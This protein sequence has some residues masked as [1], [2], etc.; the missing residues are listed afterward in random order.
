MGRPVATLVHDAT[1]NG[2]GNVHAGALH[3]A[4]PPQVHRPAEHVAPAEQVAPHAPHEVALV[5]VFVSQPSSASR[6]QSAVLAGH[7]SVAP[8]G[9]MPTAPCKSV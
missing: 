3:E 2:R 5:L 1:G 4:D 6:L 9:R 7:A 8:R